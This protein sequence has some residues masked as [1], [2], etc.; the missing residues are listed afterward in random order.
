MTPLINGDKA[1]LLKYKK[2]I[3]NIIN[4]KLFLI[5][6]EGEVISNG[7]KWILAVR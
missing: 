5:A 6:F 4:L 7:A 1:F 2:F 3:T